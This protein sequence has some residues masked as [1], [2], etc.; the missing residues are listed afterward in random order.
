[1]TLQTIQQYYTKVEKLIQYG[2]SRNERAIRSAFQNL[3]EQYCA[4]KNLQLIP[5]LDYKT[6]YGTTVTPDGTLKDAL[7]QDWGYWESKDQFD[8]L[9]EEIQN[10]LDKGYPT[11]NIL[12]E[13]SQTTVLIQN[14]QE[15]GRVEINNPASLHELLVQFVSYEPKEVQTFRQAI[16]KFKQ[17]LPGLLTELR[18]LIETQAQQNSAFAQ[19]RNDFLELCRES[20]NP[21]IVLADVREMLIQH[22]LTEDIFITIFNNAQFHRENN[23]ARELSKIIQTFLTGSIRQ[24]ILSKIDPYIK[25]IKAAASSIYD[26]HE[27]QRFL[28]VVYEN[29]YR[30]YNPA[31]ADRLGIIYTPNEIVRF[32]VG[33]ADYLTYKHFNRVLGDK[34]VEIL[35]PATGTGTFITEIIEYLPK[36]CLQY[37]YE[38]EIHCNEVAILP[39]YIANLNIEYTFFQKMG[40][41]SEFKNIC[42]VDT[43]DNLGFIFDEKQ[44]H[45]L[46]ISAENL[47]RIKQ[48]NQRKIS[49]IIG[50]PPYNA[51]QLNENENNKNR[52]YPQIDKRI[53]ETYIKNSTAQKTKLYDMYSRFIRWASDRLPPN[54]VLAFITNRS[55]INARTYDGFR[56]VVSDEF[57]DIY[58]IDLGGDVRA[59]PKLS[60]PKHNVFAI[61]TGVAITFFVKNE[62]GKG[63]PCNIF[64]TRR[65]EMETAREKLQFLATTKLKDLSFDRIHPDKNNNWINLAQNEW[66]NFLPVAYQGNAKIIN[67][68]S[69]F[70]RSC[71]GVVTARDE[72][73]YDLNGKTLLEKILFL[74]S[75]YNADLKKYQ[76]LT[77]QTSID[78]FVDY[79]IKW[80]AGLKTNLLNNKVIKFS[81]HKL[82]TSAYRPFVDKKYYFEPLLSDRLT[83]HHLGIFGGS[84]D[85]PNIIICLSGSSSNKPFQSLVSNKVCSFDFLEKTQCLPLHHYD[86]HGNRLDNITDWALQQFREHCKDTKI[87]KESIFLYVYAVLHHPLYREKYAIN[88][89]RELPRIPFYDNFQQWESWG[90]QLMDLHINYE[91]ANPYPLQRIDLKAD[92]SKPPI[93]SKP[94]LKADKFAN[95]IRLDTITTLKNIPPEVWEYKLGNRSALEWILEYYKERKPKDPTILQKFNTYRFADYKDQVIDLLARVCTVSVKTMQIIGEM[96]SISNGDHSQ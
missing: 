1:M 48:Q 70:I 36:N 65:P 10:K 6:K 3:L 27:K 57:S 38:N 94:L 11:T 89:K 54:G 51:N 62:H 77:T 35:D 18:A 32:M 14:G 74:I 76:A 29:F 58:I 75:V 45:F 31:G 20:I 53:K 90:R 87:T 47:E 39:Y 84:A 71:P 55:F 88:L 12:F 67:Q 50:N 86:K 24:N 22:I 49:V 93:K 95:S 91:T 7:R 21:H 15:V 78:D 59:N 64:Y 42:F 85:K 5:E 8:L 33:A 17:D 79:Q 52:P 69:I 26:H 28:K 72:W 23:I 40:F 46:S 44:S 56:K 73:V 63:I 2:G 92:S 19:A 13:D 30:A 43:L 4:D 80:S 34:D 9:D 81:R 61:Q 82:A 37:K 25:V 60:G 68:E 83:R 96:G 66:D 41:Y 16:D